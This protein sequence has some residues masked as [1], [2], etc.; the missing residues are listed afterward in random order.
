MNKPFDEYCDEPITDLGDGLRI[1]NEY[2]YLVLVSDA[3]DVIHL[4]HKVRRKLVEY[5]M[6]IENE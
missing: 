5:I 2:G 1:K 4:D 6:R 3:G